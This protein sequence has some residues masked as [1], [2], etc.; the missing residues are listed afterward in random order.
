MLSG[1]PRGIRDPRPLIALPNRSGPPPALTDGRNP[2]DRIERLQAET[3]EQKRVIASLA[4]TVAALQRT[5]DQMDALVLEL[6]PDG[7]LARVNR[8]AADRLGAAPERL[9]GLSPDR[10]IAPEH[11][12]SLAQTLPPASPET[13]SWP[14]L[15]RYLT[16]HGSLEQEVG[17]RPLGPTTATA[18][19][20]IHLLR[21]R[22]LPDGGAVLVAVEITTQRRRE[23]ALERAYVRAHTLVRRRSEFLAHM[24]HELRTPLSSIIT[25]TDSMLSGLFG[26]AANPTVHRYLQMIQRSGEHLLAITN[27]V[28]DLAKIDADRVTLFEESIDVRTVLDDTVTL[29]QAKADEAE[30]RLGVEVPTGGVRVLADRLRLC[31]VLVNLVSNGVKFTPAGGEVT[32]TVRVDQPAETRVSITVADNGIGIA[33]ADIPRVLEPFNQICRPHGRRHEGTGLGL[34]LTKKLVEL[35]GSSLVVDSSPGDGTRVTFSLRRG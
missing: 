6:G 9:C 24:T 34:P 4:D 20:S 17:F 32:V 1:P 3:A 28:L 22:C 13:A 10:L 33:S 31:Q 26:F 35:H 27:D 12:E 30:V 19:Q 7:R 21:G 15:Y 11:C 5:F 8:T 29:L 16:T 25:Y 2:T 14:V 23:A 18:D